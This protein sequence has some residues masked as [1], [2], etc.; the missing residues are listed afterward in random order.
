MTELPADRSV[1]I[2]VTNNGMG[3]S[4]TS[5]QQKLFATYTHLIDRTF[6]LQP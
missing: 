6:N 2:L 4:D 3:K 5:L 1:V